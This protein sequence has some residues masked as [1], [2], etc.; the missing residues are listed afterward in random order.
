M[1]V[2][3]TV[4]SSYA[5]LCFFLEAF[6]NWAIPG[7]FFLHFCFFGSLTVNHVLRTTLLKTGFEPWTFWISSDRSAD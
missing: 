4:L 6:F 2:F 3:Y 7:L 5:K 1:R